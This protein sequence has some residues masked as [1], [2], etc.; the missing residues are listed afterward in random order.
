MGNLDDIHARLDEQLPRLLEEHDVPGVGWAVVQD[1]Q[2]VDGA[3]G[4]LSRTTGVEAT[5]DSVFQI[6]SVTKLWTATLVMQL[7]DEGAVD[8]DRPVRTYLREFRVADEEAAERITVRQ[9]L[10]HTAGFEGDIFTDTGVGDDCLEK[11]VATL[12]EVPQLFPPGERF[13]YN[14]AGYCVLGR[15]VE[16]L[17]GR[18]YDACLREH[19]I[20]PLGLTHTAT[21][22]YEAIMFRAAV[23]H[24]EMEPGAGYVPA[25][26][27]AMA[28][29]NAPAGSMLAM[30]P[31]DL[32]AFARMHLEDG[33]AADGTRVLAP[34]TAARMHDREVDLPELGLMG[35]SWGLGFERFDTPDGTIIGHDGNTIGQAAFLRMV[36]EAGLAVALLTNGG[37][38]VSLYRDVVGQVLGELT[39]VG[40]PPLPVPPAEPRRIDAER[41]VGTYSASVFDL[42]VSQDDDQRIWIE[43]TPKGVFEELGG[44]AERTELVHYRDDML[45]PVLADRGMY[46]PHAF[47]GDDGTGHAL[48]L[49]LGRAVRRAGA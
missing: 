6:G 43:Q 5:A 34:G 3:A 17:R 49:H 40:L 20:A 39:D 13:S 4:L 15:L 28:R 24:I 32:V 27:W 21:G 22:P 44:R 2:V 23:G 41:Y 31:R 25:P 48:Y 7:V 33:R 29:S 38:A 37:D 36:P 30:R 9:L 18:P 16:V 1:D 11:Y 46:M 42:T 10:D 12:H 45:I 8:L 35:T 14:N 47:L 26:I 19:L